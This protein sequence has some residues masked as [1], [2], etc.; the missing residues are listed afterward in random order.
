[1]CKTLQTF[2]DFRLHLH[3]AADAK[4]NIFKM[5]SFW[6]SNSLGFKRKSLSLHQFST[7]L[8]NLAETD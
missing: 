1:M 5:L 6:I 4:I 8:K 2:I 7:S 3:T